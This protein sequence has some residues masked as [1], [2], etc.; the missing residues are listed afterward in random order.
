[1]PEPLEATSAL[2]YDQYVNSIS[3][4]DSAG[5]KGYGLLGKIGN[6]FYGHADQYKDQYQTYLDNLNRQFEVDQVNNTSSFKI[7][8]HSLI[9]C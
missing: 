2:S 4:N 3:S 5:Q 6:F 1:M 9:L 8:N 7:S